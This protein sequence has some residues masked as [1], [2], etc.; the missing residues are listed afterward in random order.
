MTG[1]FMFTQFLGFSLANS[2]FPSRVLTNMLNNFWLKKK[3]QV[4]ADTQN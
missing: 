4:V 1:L 2:I 3:K